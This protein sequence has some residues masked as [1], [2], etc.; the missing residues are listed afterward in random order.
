MHAT[1]FSKNHAP[2]LVATIAAL[3]IYGALSYL[4]HSET[5]IWDESRYVYYAQNLSQGFYVTDENPDFVNGPGY[6]LVLLPFV[7]SGGAGLLAARLLNAV[8]MAGTVWFTWLLLREY[9]ARKWAAAGAW[10]TLFH[11]VLLSRGFSIMTEP[12]SM[13]CIT[14][15]AWSCAAALRTKSRSMTVA[16]VLFLAWLTL[17]RVFFG[18]VMMATAVLSMLL[19]PFFKAWRAEL[20]RMILI[21]AG[22]FLFCTP[23]L[24][25][26]WQKTGRIL[27]WSTNSGEL[28]Y[29]MTSHN[30]GENGYWFD[31][32]EALSNP[33]LAPYH[34]EFHE[35]VVDLPILEREALLT[36]QAKAN[37]RDNPARV[38]YNWVCNLCRMAFGFPRSYVTEELRTFVLV[39]TNGPLLA[40]AA[41][42]GL[43]GLWRWRSLPAE[44]WLLA[45]FAAFYIGGSSLAPALPRYSILVL[46]MVLLGI[47]SVWARHV[48][49]SLSPTSAASD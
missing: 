20:R 35:R 39:A 24:Y 12:L 4:R 11:P 17:T 13:L 19:L 41:L 7:N 5:F 36:E 33:A 43:L 37:I 18:H 30:G 21:L 34:K 29:W 22:A 32:T 28:L 6:P 14:G 31:V 9:C 15:F 48:R 3:L 26:T 45:A 16:A 49:L 47:G 1:S 8:F 23:Y 46:P 38:A 40:L 2:G 42:M 10:I 44:V 25:H 27:C